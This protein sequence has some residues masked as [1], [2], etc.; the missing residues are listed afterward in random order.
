MKK[1]QFVPVILSGGT[2]S[3]LWPLSR[4]SYPK[5]FLLSNSKNT[6]FQES[7]QRA[8]LVQNNYFELKELLITTNES[9]RFIV[10][11]QLRNIEKINYS[12]LLEP[13]GRN[14]AASL[15]LAALHSVRNGDDP[16]LLVMP[17]D[18]LVEQNDK[19]SKILRD[20]INSSLDGGIVLLGATPSRAETGYGYI[21]FDNYEGKFSEHIVKEF[22]EK[23]DQLLANQFFKAQGYL[24]NCGIFVMRAS[25]WLD[26]IK[27]FD[28]EV[29]DTAS[30]SYYS[31]TTDGFFVRPNADIFKKI[32]PTSIDYAVIEK[33]TSSMIKLK[34]IPIN[35]G[36]NDQGSWETFWRYAEK[37]KN[38]NVIY[39]DVLSENTNNSIIYAD[40]RLVV[41]SGLSNIIVV[42][43][44][45][46]IL[47][48]DM[49]KSQSVKSLVDIL[50]NNKRYETDSH[51][52]EIRPWGWYEN[53]DLGERFKVK[54]INVSPNSSLSLQKHEHRAEHWIVVSGQ[55]DIQCGEEKFKLLPNQSTYIAKGMKH[56]LSNNT[57]KNLDI[58]EIQTGNYL[59]EDDIFR[60]EDE[61]N[62]EQNK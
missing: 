41:T 26:A 6:L 32:T 43:T 55:A 30:R 16:L 4:K 52:R 51:C 21:N 31:K 2:G 34:V 11:D 20:A 56:R 45:D 19:L 44:A 62:R 7:I 37:D 27:L 24:W 36:W 47:V 60:Y 49:S 9:Y 23:P 39:G 13:E 8:F 15:T 50:K 33:C 22:I 18:H 42:E 17:S 58:I 25:L 59:E 38:N 61:Y 1:T 48:M 54:R 35:V 29:F 46:A 28:Y 5:Q 53:I 14:T 12:L 40:K 10:S 3:R 57:K